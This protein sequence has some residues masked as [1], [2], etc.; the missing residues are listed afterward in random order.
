MVTIGSITID[1]P[2]TWLAGCLVLSVVF[3]PLYFVAR[4]ASSQKCPARSFRPPTDRHRSPT[5]SSGSRNRSRPQPTPRTIKTVSGLD[6]TALDANEAAP[7]RHATASR[8]RGNHNVRSDT[9]A[10]TKTGPAARAAGHLSF[11]IRRAPCLL[12]LR[13]R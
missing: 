2:E 11:A 6:T 5:S 8:Y 3:I 9:P 10:K 7:R 13:L 1:A 4:D 12:C